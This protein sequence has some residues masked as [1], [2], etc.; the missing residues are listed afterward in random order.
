MSSKAILHF[1]ILAKSLNEAGDYLVSIETS[2]L[3]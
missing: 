1:I 3:F 2:P